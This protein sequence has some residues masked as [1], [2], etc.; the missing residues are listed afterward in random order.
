MGN[1][2]KS[3]LS[4]DIELE[5]IYHTIARYIRQARENVVKSVNNEQVI[6]YWH[7]GK[8][9]LEKEQFGQA[10]ADYGKQLIGLRH[11]LNGKCHRFYLNVLPLVKMK[12]R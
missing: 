9:I 4:L 10:R 5:D 11:N 6:A 1:I 7:V 2:K 3:S 12:K 8:S